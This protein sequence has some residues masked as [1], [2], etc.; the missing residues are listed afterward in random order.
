MGPCSWEHTSTAT[1]KKIRGDMMRKT[2]LLSIGLLTAIGAWAQDVPK[3]EVPVGFSFIKR[4]P[5]PGSHYQL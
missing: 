3:V 5:Q 1:S 4:A 2:L